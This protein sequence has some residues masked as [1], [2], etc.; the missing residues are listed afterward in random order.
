MLHAR[1]TNLKRYGFECGAIWSGKVPPVDIA[2]GVSGRQLP[3]IATNRD[4]LE[5]RKGVFAS[6]NP[7]G[8][9][10]CNPLAGLCV[11]DFHPSIGV[12]CSK[13]A[14]IVGEFGLVDAAIQ[15]QH[16]LKLRHLS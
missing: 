7:Q 8:G 3:A 9:N 12:P 15:S 14:G 13:H 5:A 10:L 2:T 6:K 16:S 4:S 11:P 1:G